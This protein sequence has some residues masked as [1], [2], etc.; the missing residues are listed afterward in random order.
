METLKYES[1]YGLKNKVWTRL[2]PHIF[3]LHD[4]CDIV[5]IKDISVGIILVPEMIDDIYFKISRLLEMANK[6]NFGA[7]NHL[8]NNEFIDSLVDSLISQIANYF[9]LELPQVSGNE[10]LVWLINEVSKK[11]IYI[12]FLGCIEIG[13]IIKATNILVNGIQNLEF[14]RC[15]ESDL[16][17]GVRISNGI[18]AVT[19]YDEKD[20]EFLRSRIKKDAK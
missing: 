10:R 3:G 15:M 4:E 11:G 20:M 14:V 12:V 7:V 16:I 17:P 18:N 2:Y 8:V 6:D 13:R 1:T 9:G 5:D 19:S